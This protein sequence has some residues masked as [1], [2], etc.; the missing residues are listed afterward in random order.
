MTWTSYHRR[1]DVLRTVVER[2]DQRRDGI[3]PTDVAGVA[4]TFRDDL[5]LLGALSLKWHTRLSGRIE[6]ELAAQPMDLEA[7]V[8][9]A[10]QSCARDLVGVRLVL[11]RALAAHPDPAVSAALEKA[12]AKEHVLLAVMAGRSST[13]DEVAA[14]VGRAIA[15]RAR[16]GL[17]VQPAVTA[18]PAQPSVLDHL[19]G[20]LRA[21]AA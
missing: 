20:R 12:A 4:E 15:E 8:V 13:T 5:D 6:A 3:L 19:L 2:A 17:T 7:A 16:A 11:D 21:L 14:R 18:A 10:W 1:G 9:R